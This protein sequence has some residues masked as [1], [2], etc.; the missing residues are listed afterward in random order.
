MFCIRKKRTRKTCDNL[1][2]V[3]VDAL[4]LIHA[5][6]NEGVKKRDPG[7]EYPGQE[8]LLQHAD[9]QTDDHP[10]VLQKIQL[11]R[12]MNGLHLSR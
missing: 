11:Q 6:V 8:H 9:A 1:S 2:F 5:V 12:C 10:D 7:D 3:V 4:V